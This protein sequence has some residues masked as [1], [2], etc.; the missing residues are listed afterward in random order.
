MAYLS[1][2]QRIGRSGKDIERDVGMRREGEASVAG[3]LEE[4]SAWRSDVS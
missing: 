2:Y 1:L 3:G 4:W